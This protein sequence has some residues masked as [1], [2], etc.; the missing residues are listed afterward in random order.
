M[1]ILH[2]WISYIYGYPIDMDILYICISYISVYPIYICI[3]YIYGYPKYMNILYIWISYIIFPEIDSVGAISISD[4]IIS[5][6]LAVALG[7]DA[8]FSTCSRLL[9]VLTKCYIDTE[10]DHRRTRRCTTVRNSDDQDIPL[11][12]ACTSICIYQ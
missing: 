4:G 12:W 6:T 3:S 7:E 10:T 9:G 11:R 2:I 5:T 8:V 1:D